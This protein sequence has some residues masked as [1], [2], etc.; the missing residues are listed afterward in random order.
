[1]RS[2]MSRTPTSSS[3]QLNGSPPSWRPSWATT[4][5]GSSS[6]EPQ[7]WPGSSAAGMTETHPMVI[8]RAKPVETPEALLAR[9]APTLIEPTSVS[10]DGES[11]E[12]VARL[13]SALFVDDHGPSYA[14]VLAGP[15][16]LVAEKERWPEGRYI[17]VDL[18][19]IGARN[20]ATRAGE[21]DRA[22]TC[23]CAE[24]LAPMG[25]G[26]IWW[27]ET[28][29]E[30]VKHTVGVSADLREGVRLSI[31]LIANDVVR[32]RVDQLLDPLPAAE[33]Q[34]LAKQSLRF[35]YRILF[36]LY[37][38]ASPELGVL[39]AGATEYDEGY[40]LDRL[41]ELIQVELATPQAINGSTPLRVTG[42]PVPSGRQGQSAAT[43]E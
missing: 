22:L 19:S 13:L 34:P 37:A 14:L 7:R 3:S 18:Q 17:A 33:A 1:M 31:E 43:F 4:L 16:A 2:P 21:I 12:S 20:D 35:L 6:R 36:L 32:R 10:E 23:L 15:W 39:P 28:L 24:S 42:D 26:S 9:D 27:D 5:T 11:L 30:A 25:E 8:V 38:E 41:R 29:K 40:S